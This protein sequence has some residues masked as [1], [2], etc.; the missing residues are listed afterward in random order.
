MLAELDTWERSQGG[1]SASGHGAKEFDKQGWAKNNRSQFDE[2]I[3]QARRGRAKAVAA[4]DEASTAAGESAEGADDKE[5]RDGDEDA[6]M[7][8]APSFTIPT[9]EDDSAATTAPY[10]ANAS[11][12]AAVKA[13]LA[14]VDRGADAPPP[15]AHTTST[16]ELPLH[17]AA[18][19]EDEARL[20]SPPLGLHARARELARPT[21]MFCV[22]AEPVSDV[23]EGG[24]GF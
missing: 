12:M 8:A 19:A 17:A 9:E 21:N 20:A 6:V 23:E 24:G 18:P 4:K 2:L 7:E 16:T 1:G 22:P 11:A 10:A 13:K 15:A 3:A 14:T 5:K